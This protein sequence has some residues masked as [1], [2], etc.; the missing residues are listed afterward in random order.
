[1]VHGRSA[2][3]GCGRRTRAARPAPAGVARPCPALRARAA[4]SPATRSSR[5]SR[6]RSLRLRPP[7]ERA[8]PRNPAPGFPRTKETAKTYELGR[9]F[10]PLDKGVGRVVVDRLE[11]LR[12]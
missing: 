6:R 7:C 8:A 5:A 9:P 1:S 12:L 10:V 4:T 3:D 11:I 2:A